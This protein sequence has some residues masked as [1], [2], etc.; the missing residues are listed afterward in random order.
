MFGGGTPGAG[1][2]YR[3][4]ASVQTG[5]EAAET[6]RSATLADART[7][8]HNEKHDQQHTLAKP[9]QGSMPDTGVVTHMAPA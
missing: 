6:E 5:A 1:G 7:E 4:S 2:P 8:F 9:Y 3:G